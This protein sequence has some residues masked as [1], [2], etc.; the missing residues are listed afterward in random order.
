MTVISDV[1]DPAGHVRGDIPEADI[2]A[3]SERQAAALSKLIDSDKEAIAGDE[4]MIAARLAVREG[5]DAYN[6]A[7]DRS[8]ALNKPQT[9]QQIL[10]ACIEA[11]RPGYVPPPS[12]GDAAIKAATRKIVVLEKTVANFHSATDKIKRKE[13][14]AE[15]AGARLELARAEAPAQAIAALQT[16]TENLAMARAE[17]VA[18]QANIQLVEHIR[19][20]AV[21]LWLSVIDRPSPLDLQRASALAYSEATQKAKAVERANP[22]PPH[23]RWEIEKIME[24][25]GRQKHKREY[26]GRL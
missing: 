15:L 1:F 19:S 3:L 13:T 12:K 20:Q 8:A 16:A 17:Y 25:R 24:A 23:D 21:V 22:A 6:A 11:N 2:L 10:L 26:L 5:N 7:F 18:A 9:H 4:R 14:N